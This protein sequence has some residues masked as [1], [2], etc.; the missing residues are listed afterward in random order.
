MKGIIKE[1]KKVIW[2][3][4]IVPCIILSLGARIIYADVSN[5]SGSVTDASS[6][7][8]IAG[9]TIIADPG[10][11]LS[12][13]DDNGDYILSVSSSGE[14][15]ITAIAIGYGPALKPVTVEEGKN[16]TLDFEL[17]QAPPPS[18]VPTV[19]PIFTCTEPSSIE[20]SSTKL[21]LK[22]MQNHDI[23]VAVKCEDGS[24]LEGQTITAKVNTAGKGRISVTSSAVTDANGEATFTIAAKKKAG[25]SRILF[26]SGGLK[27]RATVKINR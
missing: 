20:V 6:S 19:T 27:K 10:G 13:T 8:A 12:I 15:T 7:K 23:T 2:S 3:F 26:K 5:I 1:M 9:A 16:V 21:K 4:L 18:P 11:I 22:R 14:Y 17:L 25:I 24:P